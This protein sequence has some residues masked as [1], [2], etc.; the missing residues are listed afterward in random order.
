MQLHKLANPIYNTYIEPCAKYIYTHSADVYRARE[1][2][3]V[4][5]ADR[6]GP[7]ERSSAFRSLEVPCTLILPILSIASAFRKIVAGRALLFVYA[8]VH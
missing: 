8:D 5:S 4:S 3:S 1:L 7:R 2:F 6:P